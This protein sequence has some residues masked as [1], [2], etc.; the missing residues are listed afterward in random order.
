M[1]I[2]NQ[3]LTAKDA[4]NAKNRLVWQRAGTG[5][6][7]EAVE[8]IHGEEWMLSWFDKLWR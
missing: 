3:E 1:K 5:R 8:R 4:E 6:V 7:I 2:E